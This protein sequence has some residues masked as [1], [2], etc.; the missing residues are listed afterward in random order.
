MYMHIF[1]RI[2]CYWVLVNI[3]GLLNAI[4]QKKK[5]YQS[6]VHDSVAPRSQI[7]IFSGLLATKTAMPGW[8]CRTLAKSLSSFNRDIYSREIFFDNPVIIKE[9]YYNGRRDIVIRNYYKKIAGY[10]VTLTD[11]DA[12]AIKVYI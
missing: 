7:D 4:F 1:Y 5:K 6:P 12:Y 9:H 10:K 3:V 8:S 2:Y 11:Q